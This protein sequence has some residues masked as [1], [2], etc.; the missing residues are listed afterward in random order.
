MT[1]YRPGRKVGRT[2]YRQDGAEPSDADALVGLVDTPELASRICRAL[3]R[4][5]SEA[6][7]ERQVRAKVAAEVAEPS[8]W[9]DPSGRWSAEQADAARAMKQH[10]VRHITRGRS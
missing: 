1:R 4:E 3:N 10:I 5:T 7:H 8:V 9:A 2:L 6:E